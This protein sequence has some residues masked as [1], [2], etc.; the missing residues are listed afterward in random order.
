LLFL[1]KPIYSS[2]RAKGDA[3]R[4]IKY[5]FIFILAPLISV[6]LLAQQP[7]WELVRKDFWG[8]IAIDPTT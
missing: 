1:P 4:I 3:M 5:L 2:L 7:A 6:N 8:K